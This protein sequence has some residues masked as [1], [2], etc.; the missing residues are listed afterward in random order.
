MLFAMPLEAG[1]MD[2]SVVL[3]EKVKKKVGDLRENFHKIAVNLP[4]TYEKI[5]CKGEP[6][7]FSS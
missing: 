6:Y 3:V 4:R 5:P 7:R 1:D 2:P